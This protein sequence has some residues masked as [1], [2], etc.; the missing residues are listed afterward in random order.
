MAD[1]DIKPSPTSNAYLGLQTGLYVL[2]LVWTGFRL[3]IRRGRHWWE[4]LFALM[5]AFACIVGLVSFW[6]IYWPNAPE[7]DYAFM[8]LD[9]M[10][11]WVVVWSTR[12]SVLLSILRVATKPRMR[13]IIHASLSLFAIFGAVSFAFKMWVCW[14]NPSWRET[15][16]LHCRN[17][18]AYAFVQLSTDVVSALILV[19]LPIAMLWDI[20]L[21]RQTRILVISIFAMS[22]LS[23]VASIV[24]VVFIV[25]AT[26]ETGITMHIQNAID[27]IVC[28]LLVTVTFIYRVLLRKN[29]AHIDD[30]T[31]HQGN[32]SNGDIEDSPETVKFT[33]V[34]LDS[35][36]SSYAFDS[37]DSSYQGRS[38][39][40]W[41][42]GLGQSARWL[43]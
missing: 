23:A 31:S 43:E 2:A 4:D 7:F 10:T 6:F 12:V 8:W 22:V 1:Q 36:E 5:A 39:V 41:D 16:Y 25:P 9:I 20:K 42:R 28:N 18:H 19:T 13:I 32:D 30:G 24:H 29:G 21:A 35:H 40:A 17:S 26:S 37:S 15:A 3:W 14:D 27:L 33:T 11:N 38:N 34:N